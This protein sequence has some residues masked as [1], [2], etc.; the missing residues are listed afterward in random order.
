MAMVNRFE[1]YMINL[2]PTLSADAKNTRPCVVLS[3]D[4]LNHTLR[5]VIVAPLSS[6]GIRYPTRIPVNFLNGQRS[7]VLDQIRTVDK[8]RLI[9]KIGEIER[10]E[11]QET[12]ARLAELFAE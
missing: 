12:L 4:E 2:D 5:T 9:K 1:I 3:P 6:T 7:I 10:L 11:K 8:E